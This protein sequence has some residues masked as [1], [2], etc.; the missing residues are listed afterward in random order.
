MR[1]KTATLF[2]PSFRSAVKSGGK[3][4]GDKDGLLVGES[5]VKSRLSDATKEDKL[6]AETLQKPFKPYKKGSSR[7]AG[8]NGYKGEFFPIL[9]ELLFLTF[10]V[11]GKHV[12]VPS[13]DL[14][15]P[16]VRR[17][18]GLDLLETCHNFSWAG[19]SISTHAIQLECLQ[20]E[21]HGQKVN[22]HFKLFKY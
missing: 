20:V 1:D 16:G 22:F 5:K 13:L 8:Y 12:P 17:L 6:L 14:G 15:L 4:E 19:T 21:E 2:S 3:L 9:S 7:S 18:L 11:L 10:F